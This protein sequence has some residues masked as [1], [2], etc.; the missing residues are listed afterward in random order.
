MGP[1]TI[2]RQTFLAVDQTTSGLLDGSVSGILGLAFS[3]IASTRSTPFW[4]ALLNN[5]DL[6]EPDMGFWLKRLRGQSGVSLEEPGGTFTLGG[7][8]SSLFTGDIEFLP[9]TGNQRT[10]WL[11][12][13]QSVTVDGQNIRIQTGNAAVSAIDTGTT[14]VGGPT[15]DVNA[16][17]AAVPGS[18]KVQGMDGFFSFPCSTTV[19]VTMSFGGKAWPINPADMSLGRLAPGSSQ[20]LGGIFDLS[21]GSSIVSGGGNPNWVV[22]GTFLKNVYSVFRAD[23]PSIGFAQLSDSAGGS[24]GTVSPASSSPLF[25]SLTIGSPLSSSSSSSSSLSSTSPSNSVSPSPTSPGNSPGNPGVATSTVVVTADGAA[26]TPGSGGSSGNSGSTG[27]GRNSA[28]S[29]RGMGAAALVI[30]AVVAFVA[31]L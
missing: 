27:S 29:A 8:N 18:Q 11:L 9:M 10:F 6:T 23:P 16:I 12:N 21:L 15:S 1:F 28:V 26:G 19:R 24:S 17:W 2:Q 5:G 22:G 7:T 14:L 25:S 31:L 30:P 20:C 3:A 13:M 4:Q